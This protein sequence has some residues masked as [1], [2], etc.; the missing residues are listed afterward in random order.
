MDEDPD[1]CIYGGVLLANAV[2]EVGDL[3]YENVVIS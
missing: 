1:V 3:F 2:I